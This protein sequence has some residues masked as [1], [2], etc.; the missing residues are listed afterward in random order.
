MWHIIGQDKAVSLL[1][2]SLD[3][4][5][6]AHAYLLVGP[7]SVGK[8]TLAL[9]LA[10]A[11]NCEQSQPPCGEC[12][13][14]HKIASGK[15]ADVQIIGL[16]GNGASTEARTRTEI[17]IDQ[18]RQIQHT[19]S[20]PPFEGKCRVYIIDGAEQMSTE[21]SNCLLKTLEE[22]VDRVVFILL[23]TSEKLLLETIISR[24]QRIELPPLGEGEVE[25]ALIK[26]WQV[27]QQKAHLLSR[28]SHG[29]L[30]WAIDALSDDGVL[31]QREERL[32][33]F[34]EVMNSDYEERFACASGVAFQFS[35]NRGMVFELLTLWRDFWHDVMMVKTGV[36][37][38]VS[39]VD[40]LDK[41]I[42][43]AQT[44]S[45]AQIRNVIRSIETTGEQLKLN[46]N[47]QLVLEVLM[48]S[49][50]CREEKIKKAPLANL[51]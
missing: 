30:G 22:P 35:R 29:R 28:L 43:M 12:D 9:N 37:E 8:T 31:Q 19:A 13:S 27:E 34:I 20:L 48:L 42:E 15:H 14:C 7:A 51:R 11:L 2:R 39:N 47:P 16:A 10:Q 41:L 6:L 25:Q 49:I 23:S 18:I 33:T 45:L 26:H 4:G 3:K 21:A 38:V 1:Q 5:K 40:Y 17:S 36:R 24:C 32:N 44:F 46:V 50:P